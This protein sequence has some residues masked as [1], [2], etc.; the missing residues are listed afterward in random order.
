M[1][2]AFNNKHMRMTPSNNTFLSLINKWMACLPLLLMSVLPLS[3]QA[4]E[5]DTALVSKALSKYS[6]ENSA[7][8]NYKEKLEITL[9]NGELVA[10]TY[11]TWDRL[12][13][14][15]VS[16]QES[17]LDLTYKSYFNKIQHYD[18]VAYI[19]K[20]NGGYKTEDHFFIQKFSSDRSTFYDDFI[21]V[22]M[23]F[24]GLKQHSVI[25]GSVTHYHP[26]LN[27]L[28]VMD[29]ALRYPA[30]HC[31]LEIVVPDYV[32]IKSLKKGPW[33]DKLNYTKTQKNG[34]TTYTYT[35][36][37]VPAYEQ[38]KDVPSFFYD[39]TYVLNYISSYRLPNESKDSVLLNNVDDLYKFQYKYVGNLNIKKDTVL[40]KLVAEITKGDKS[41]KD[42]AAH[43]YKWVQDN[44][45]YIAIEAGLA[46]WIPREADTVLK[47]KFGDCKDMASLLTTMYRAAGMEAYLTWVGTTIIPFKAEEIPAPRLFNHMICALHLDGEWIFVDGT[48]ATLPFNTNRADIQGKQVLI[49]QDYK[50]YKLLTIPEVAADKNSTVDSTTIQIDSLTH[51]SISGKVFQSLKGYP[52]W[53]THYVALYLKADEKDKW[54]RKHT[55]RGN[56][57][58]AVDKYSIKEVKNVNKDLNVDVDYSIDNYVVASGKN[59][60]INMNMTNTYADRW[61]DLSNRKVGSYYDYKEKIKDVVVLNIPKGY[62]VS[63]LPK[64]VQGGDPNVWTY[65]INY[66]VVGNTIVLTKEYTTNTREVS[67]NLLSTTNTW[68]N[69]LEKQY[70]ETVVLTAK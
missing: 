70:Q 49:A 37:N 34:K 31:E 52:S 10:R 46:G 57:R 13:I 41:A 17:L 1:L 67:R 7:Y 51:R 2:R 45:H 40:E 14:S 35:M 23:V 43:I 38:D 50:N 66:K 24:T 16:P 4:A 20:S 53:N 27:A 65:K 9:E 56:D 26:E 18:A 29:L 39:A 60:I 42:K 6:K 25:S 19:P 8:L 69:A 36:D 64:P 44:V 12:L 54:I 58:Y 59:L 21:N 15:P 32:N 62:K 47:R 22:A 33:I 61:V 11:T 28:P 3:S 48:A 30:L 68:A 5:P 55:L 63:Y